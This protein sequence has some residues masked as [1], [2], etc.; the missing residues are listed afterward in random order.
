MDANNHE[1]VDKAKTVR[2][3]GTFYNIHN[4]VLNSLPQNATIVELGV[5]WGRGLA[6]MC[7]L[8]KTRGI[9][10]F[11]VDHFEGTKGESKETYFGD[12]HSI[13]EQKVINTLNEIGISENDYTLIVG[14]T[15]KSANLFAKVDY[16]FI[17]A[18]HSYEGVCADITAWWPKIPLGGFMGGH[19][20]PFDPVRKAVEDNFVNYQVID[21]CWL[22]R[23]V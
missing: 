20:L 23:K 7:A 11:G 2:G 18:D 17:D 22:V 10:V 6:M 9:K 12:T 14:D 3:W 13:S 16:V 5:A 1:L 21:D 19:D 4:Q 15:M 8:A